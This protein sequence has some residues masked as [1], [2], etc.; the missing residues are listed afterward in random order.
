MRQRSAFPPVVNHKRGPGHEADDSDGV[1]RVGD[2]PGAEDLE[3]FPGIAEIV[4][5]LRAAPTIQELKAE[6]AYC[7]LFDTVNAQ[8]QR[9][10]QAVRR[11]HGTGDRTVVVG[12]R[13]ALIAAVAVAAIGA[14]AAAYAG[15]LPARL[16]QSAHRLIGAP[17]PIQTNVPQ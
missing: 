2:V 3:Q 10:W 11:P 7:Q 12:T 13:A 5:A 14:T 16:Q 6:H 4:V 17:G 1:G 15:A 8:P 9:D